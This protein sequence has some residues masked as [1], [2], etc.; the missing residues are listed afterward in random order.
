MPSTAGFQ[1][2]EELNG[3]QLC[4]SQH[5]QDMELL[6]Q[7]QRSPARSHRDCSTSKDRLGGLGTFSLGKGRSCG[8]LTDL[9]G[10]EG[11]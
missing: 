1:L 9:A 4:C 3:A 10:S 6:E 8:D 2:C 7:V 5:Q 11:I